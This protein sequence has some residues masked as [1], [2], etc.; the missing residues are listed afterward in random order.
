MINKGELVGG[1]RAARALNHATLFVMPSEDAD[2]LCDMIIRN[3]N[4]FK[5][6]Q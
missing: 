3:Y 1:T 4:G 2:K 6:M 5:K